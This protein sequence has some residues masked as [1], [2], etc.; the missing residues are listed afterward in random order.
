MLRSMC[1]LTKLESG[2][3]IQESVG[4]YVKVLRTS[5]EKK[6]VSK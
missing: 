2:R 5:K 4:E 1:E 6:N 3:H